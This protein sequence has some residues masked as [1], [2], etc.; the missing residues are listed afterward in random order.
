MTPTPP[1]ASITTCLRLSK[2][3]GLARRGNFAAAQQVFALGSQ[4]PEDP[5]ELQALAALVTRQGD[6]TRALHLWRTLEQRVPAHAEARRMINAIELWQA[7]PAWYQFIPWIAGVVALLVLGL[8]ANAAL[9]DPPRAAPPKPAGL[10]SP[11]AVTPTSKPQTVPTP[12]PS[13]Q[14]SPT[15]KKQQR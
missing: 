4:L 12:A 3:M 1:A 5:I 13:I 15:Q 11:A 10:V 7:R 8:L 14:V 2:A 6:F 9:S